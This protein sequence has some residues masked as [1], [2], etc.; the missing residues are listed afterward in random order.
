M[1][2]IVAQAHDPSVGAALFERAPEATAALAMTD[3][4]AVTILEEAKR[5][6]VAVPRDFSVMGFDGVAA[7][8]HSDP[9]LTTIAHTVVEKGRIAARMILGDAPSRQVVL[10]VQLVGRASTAA[11]RKT[12][13]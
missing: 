6:G 5:R 9:P 13:R 7:G 3:R 11:P 10:P 8:A 4:Q 2:V 12:G 1:P